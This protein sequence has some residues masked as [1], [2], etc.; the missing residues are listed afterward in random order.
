MKDAVPSQNDDAGGW[1]RT[2]PEAV[3]R[4]LASRTEGDLDTLRR[5]PEADLAG[6]HFG[7]ALY[8]RN[9]FGLWQG[10]RELL[11]AALRDA[12]GLG[13]ADAASTAIVHALW[14]RL[15]ERD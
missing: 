14:T 7:L 2:V 15:R 13:D 1:P 12:G 9:E 6:L 10:N 3:E 11:D 8:V 4:L 5:T